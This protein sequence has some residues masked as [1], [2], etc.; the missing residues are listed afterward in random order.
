MTARSTATVCLITGLTAALLA[1]LGCGR[2]PATPQFEILRD[3]DIEL[4]G[5]KWKG[6][7]MSSDQHFKY[8]N[9]NAGRQF[10]VRFN[11]GRICLNDVDHGPV[12]SGDRIRATTEQKLYVNDELRK[13]S[14]K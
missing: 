9:E 11:Q 3:I 4:P 5:L 7:V 12:K 8:R 13:P 1:V 6:D 2:E 10:T 14:D